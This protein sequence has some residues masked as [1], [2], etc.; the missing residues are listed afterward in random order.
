MAM[1]ALQLLKIVP[2]L[3]N[4]TLTIKSSK[5]TCTIEGEGEAVEEVAVIHGD[6][7]VE[8]VVEVEEEVVDGDG[9]GGGGGG[10][11]GW[12]KWGCGGK[13]RHGRVKGGR[14]G[15]P[16]Y[17]KE[18]YGEEEYKLGEFAECMGKTRC[19]GMRLDC[20]LHCGGPCLYD[21]HHMCKAHC[22]R[23]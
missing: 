21:C 6:G 13:P 3:Q 14:R 4:T 1:P 9:D 8:V 17:R 20:P 15:I 2:H 18:K 23:P 12:W 11:G 16:H 7:V 10:G 19:R 22:R 5:V